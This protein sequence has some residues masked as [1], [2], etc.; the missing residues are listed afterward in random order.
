MFWKCVL[1]LFPFLVIIISST[2]VFNTVKNIVAKN[3]SCVIV[4]KLSERNYFNFLKL[5]L[6]ISFSWNCYG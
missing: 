1:V 2:V 4:E 5:L 6:N 3:E